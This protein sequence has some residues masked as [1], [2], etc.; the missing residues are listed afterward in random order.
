MIF[1]NILIK[2]LHQRFLPLIQTRGTDG[3]SFVPHIEFEYEERGITNLALHFNNLIT[4]SLLSYIV[5]LIQKGYHE[6]A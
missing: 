1:R 4:R 5:K 2:S 3:K 6:L